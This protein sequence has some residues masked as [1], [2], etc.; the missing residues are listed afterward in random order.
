ML[1][2]HLFSPLLSVFNVFLKVIYLLNLHKCI[3]YLYILYICSCIQMWT[4]WTCLI[5][6]WFSIIA[7]GY[8]HACVCIPTFK[9]VNIAPVYHYKNTFS[10]FHTTARHTLCIK[11]L[12]Y[13]YSLHLM[14]LSV[15]CHSVLFMLI[16]QSTMWL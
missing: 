8:T 13:K 3:Y 16:N 2:A 10:Y 15:T 14:N 11:K 4:A 12:F 6:V 1:S 9:S 5:V 7:T